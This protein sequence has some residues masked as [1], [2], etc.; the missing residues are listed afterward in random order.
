MDDSEGFAAILPVSPKP[1]IESAPKIEESG[2]DSLSPEQRQSLRDNQLPYMERVVHLDM[3]GAAP[4]LSYLEVVF[5]L[6]SS[7]GA[8]GLLVGKSSRSGCSY[9]SFLWLPEKAPMTEKRKKF[10]L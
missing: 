2:A 10:S 3:K 7:L 1:N 8:T 4:K 9:A 5:P 6:L